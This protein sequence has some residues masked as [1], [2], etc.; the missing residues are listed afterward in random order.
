LAEL[1]AKNKNLN[2]KILQKDDENKKLKEKYEQRIIELTNENNIFSDN[3][4]ELKIH[5][6]KQFQELN[7]LNQNCGYLEN[8]LKG[9]KIINNKN[10]VHIQE[11]SSISND[12]KQ[13]Y[14]ILSEIKGKYLENEKYLENLK[15]EYDSEVQKN[16]NLS[17]NLNVLIPYFRKLVKNTSF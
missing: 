15:Y 16:V 1:I 5:L 9:Q 6:N 14:E 2:N 4:N 11:L 17:R 12:Y 10:Q 8:E 13:Q 7:E 3:V